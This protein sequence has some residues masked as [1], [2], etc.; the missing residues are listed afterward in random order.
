MID[1]PRWHGWANISQVKQM[2]IEMIDFL[3]KY[4]AIDYPK[5]NNLKMM[6]NID[7]LEKRLN[8]KLIKEISKEYGISLSAVRNATKSAVKWMEYNAYL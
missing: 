3:K 8:G 1:D 6:R 2:M 5:R 7:I 4:D